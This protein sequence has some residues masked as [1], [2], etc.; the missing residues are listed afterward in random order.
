MPC[1]SLAIRLGRQTRHVECPPPCGNQGDSSL[2]ASRRVILPCSILV[3]ITRVLLES[4][5][6]EHARAFVRSMSTLCLAMVTA[7][8]INQ[9]ERVGKRSKYTAQVLAC[10]PGLR[11]STLTVPLR[12]T[13]E[14]AAVCTSLGNG[15]TRLST[16]GTWNFS[17]Q[18]LSPGTVDEMESS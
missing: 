11:H 18:T 8:G 5:K 16:S 6:K 15:R 17:R 10:S 7:T 2:L 4:P 13:R 9:F 3:R 1:L 14:V 12:T